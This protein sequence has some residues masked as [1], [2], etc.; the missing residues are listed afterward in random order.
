MIKGLSG[1]IS[2]WGCASK[3][4]LSRVVPDLGLPMIKK[5]GIAD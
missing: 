5:S 4:T 2:T 1:G 3:S